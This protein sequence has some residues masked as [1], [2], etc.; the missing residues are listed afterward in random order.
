MCD[1]QQ[2]C[3]ND[4]CENKQQQLV[5]ASVPTQQQ[6]PVSVTQNQIPA[7]ILQDAELNKWIGLLP[8]NY[9][10]E[11]HKTVHRIRELGS[12][13]VALQF[14]EGIAPRRNI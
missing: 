5:K 12:T 10:F 8:G 6:Q 4:G 3:N 1:A 9:N 7:E 2:Q 11:I 13:S 14:P